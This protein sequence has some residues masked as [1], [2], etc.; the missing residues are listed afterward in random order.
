[1]VKKMVGK[2][3]ELKEDEKMLLDAINDPVDHTSK[4]NIRLLVE[5]ARG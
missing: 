3:G 2:E 5:H 4:A 1:M